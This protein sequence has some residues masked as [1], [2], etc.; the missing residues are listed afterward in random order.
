MRL[1]VTRV[2]VNLKP[3]KG[4]FTTTRL[5]VNTISDITGLAITEGYIYHHNKKYKK[6]KAI[7]I[8]INNFA[9][10]VL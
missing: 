2:V 5:T 7:E 6:I 9:L 8:L 4:T 10:L 1:L 3:T